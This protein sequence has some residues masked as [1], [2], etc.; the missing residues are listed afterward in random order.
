MVE[1]HSVTELG[2]ISTRIRFLACQ[3]IELCLAGLFAKAEVLPF[4]SSVN[5]FGKRNSD[6]DMIVVFD[7]NNHVTKPEYTDPHC[8]IRYPY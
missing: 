7:T 1:F 2:S 4:G 5:S 6:L 3:Q 8:L